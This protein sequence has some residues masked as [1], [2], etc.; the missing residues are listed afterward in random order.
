GGIITTRPTATSQEIRRAFLAL[1]RTTHPDKR[2]PGDRSDSSEFQKLSSF[3]KTQQT[4]AADTTRPTMTPGDPMRDINNGKRTRLNVKPRPK[5]DRRPI[6]KTTEERKPGSA[7]KRRNRRERKHANKLGEKRTKGGGLR[8]ERPRKSRDRPRSAKPDTARSKL[9]TIGEETSKREQMRNNRNRN[10]GLTSSNGSEPVSSS[11]DEKLPAHWKTEHQRH[12]Y[13]QRQEKEARRKELEKAETDRQ[14]KLEAQEVAPYKD[15]GRKGNA[16]RERHRLQQFK[17]EDRW[18]K[19]AKMV[20]TKRE[21]LSEVRL[22]ERTLAS[23]L[24]G[25]HGCSEC[26]H[27]WFGWTE[28]AG[29]A[30]CGWCRQKAATSTFECTIC[31]IKLCPQCKHRLAQVISATLL[32]WVRYGMGQANA[33]KIDKSS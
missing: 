17:T 12:Q 7:E 19:L 8:G 15:K 30:G 31:R 14:L 32:N 18:K 25:K 16:A 21:R 22:E 11:S 5:L 3:F 20:R 29:G 9:P 24:Y 33:M 1:A 10:F 6:T 27:A 28:K 26:G 2:A 23:M 13:Q 4:A